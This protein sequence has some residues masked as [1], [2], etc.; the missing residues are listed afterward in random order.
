[1]AGLKI[2]IFHQFSNSQKKF[3]YKFGWIS[4]LFCRRAINC[5][6]DWHESE[7]APRLISI[8]KLA[9]FD[10]LVAVWSRSRICSHPYT[11]YATRIRLNKIVY[12]ISLPPITQWAAVK[13]QL[14]LINPTAQWTLSVQIAPSH[15]YPTLS[16][17]PIMR[18][19]ATLIFQ[20]KY[21]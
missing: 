4:I 7:L 13:T 1:M 6:T 3:F 10:K 15:G 21:K 12:R 14:S 19:V 8:S 5:E 18:A 11:N 2:C 20:M 17:P 9:N 16:I